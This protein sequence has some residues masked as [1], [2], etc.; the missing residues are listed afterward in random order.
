MATFLDYKLNDDGDYAIE[1]A[2][3]VII[4][5]IDVVKQQVETNLKLSK[6][7]WFLNFDEGIT[8]FDNQNGLLGSK[9][10]TTFNEAE[11]QIAIL[12]TDGIDTINDFSYELTNNSLTVNIIANTIFGQVEL[13]T[14]INI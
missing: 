11:L 10:L 3:F 13:N 12:S 6:K 2:D 8:F 4:Q 9:S 5:D 7:D 14:V 1:N